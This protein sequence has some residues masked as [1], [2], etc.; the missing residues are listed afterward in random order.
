MMFFRLSEI[1]VDDIFDNKHLVQ[2]WEQ[3]WTPFSESM[4]IFLLGGISYLQLKIHMK[5]FA[6]KVLRALPVVET[7][8]CEGLVASTLWWKTE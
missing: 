4:F 1:A 3:V 8:S 5:V 6:S 7:S 2:Q